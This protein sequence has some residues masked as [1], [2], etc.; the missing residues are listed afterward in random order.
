MKLLPI[1]KNYREN[2]GKPE[3]FLLPLYKLEAAADTPV[4]L[5]AKE[6]AGWRSSTLG[7]SPKVTSFLINTFKYLNIFI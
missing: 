2:Q 3:K 6:H 1:Y 4:G 5:P 7:N